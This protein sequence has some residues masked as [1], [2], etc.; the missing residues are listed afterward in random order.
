MRRPFLLI[1]FVV[2]PVMIF[3]QE[4]I[5]L[6]DGTVTFYVPVGTLMA[7][8]P[9]E[10]VS[11]EEYKKYYA[12]NAIT[13]N[14]SILK[15]DS[16]TEG[17]TEE[18]MFERGFSE[19]LINLINNGNFKHRELLELLTLSRDSTAFK[20]EFY[21]F[22]PVVNSYAFI[23]YNGK[24]VGE[25]YGSDGSIDVVAP[26]TYGYAMHLV[27]N[28]CIVSIG[29][30]LW[31]KDIAFPPQMPDYFYFNKTNYNNYA[32]HDFYMSRSMLYHKLSKYDYEGLPE[33]FKKLRETLDM[34][35]N[36][37]VIKGYE[38]ENPTGAVLRFA[39]P[40][41][42]FDPS[43]I[44][45]HADEKEED[46]IKII[47]DGGIKKGFDNK[48]LSANGADVASANKSG[49]TKLW[50]ILLLFVPL[51]SVAVFFVIRKRKRT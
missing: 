23:E 47:S 36:T 4:Q 11:D 13:I 2:F 37:L 32:W 12:D 28:D 31:D 42:S 30:G 9:E 50:L 3:A 26:A 21:I 8:P 45:K 41:L 27:V 7:I 18:E 14:P 1:F 29:V 33:K 46:N 19:E 49:K 51:L 25:L 34:V 38:N 6:L 44:V 5:S 15:A 39:N 17:F 40:E 48:I 16:F 20:N 43:Q 22:Q 10:N 24:T 35:L